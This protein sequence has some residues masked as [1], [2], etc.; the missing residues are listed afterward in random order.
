MPNYL[1]KC[2]RCEDIIEFALPISHD[3]K[4]F[5]NHPGHKNVCLG[6]YYR[7]MR[8][9]GAVKGLKTFAGDWFKKTYGSDIG[10]AYIDKA[11]QREDYETMKRELDKE[12]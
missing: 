5:C 4:Q 3:P 8:A 12:R 7:I 11:R 10:D 2:N 9:P 6:L 1:Y